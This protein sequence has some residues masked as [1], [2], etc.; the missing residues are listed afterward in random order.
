MHAH[1]GCV[2]SA[3]NLRI[4]SD[5]SMHAALLIIGCQQKTSIFCID[6]NLRKTIQLQH[7]IQ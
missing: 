4:R 1:F 6:F 2:M 7:L 3:I 5:E